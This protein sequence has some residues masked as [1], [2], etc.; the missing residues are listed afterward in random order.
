MTDTDDV[1]GALRRAAQAIAPVAV[2][3]RRTIHRRPEPAYQEHE[4]AALVA[5]VLRD[6]GL[7]VRAGV[8]GTTGVVGLLHG[9]AA[10]QNGGACSGRVLAIRADMDALPIAGADPKDVPYRTTVEGVRHVCGHDAHVAMALGAAQAL[11]Q[12]RDRWAGTVKFVFEPAEESLG[13]AFKPGADALIEAGVLDD[14]PVDAVLALHVFPEYPAGTVAVRPG[15]IMTGMDLLDV[16]VI[17][18]EAHS[19]T[20]QKGADAIVAAAHVIL[21]LQ[22]LASREIDPT[23]AVAVN[24]G[25]IEGGRGPRNLLAGRVTLRGLV[26]ASNPALRAEL[27]ERVTRIANHA[28]AALRARCDVRVTSF[29]PSVN[30]DPVVTERF[31]AAC[32]RALGPERVLRLPL[33]R[34]VGETFCAYSERVP[35]VLAFLG[36][37]NPAK[38]ETMWPSH[39]PRFDVDEDALESGILAL[40]AAALELLTGTELRD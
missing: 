9:A 20:P 15:V 38:P 26:R 24:I 21:A 31:I 13:E 37:G 2:E 3:W 18:E 7:G 28:A 8:G 39:H 19:S 25:T 6:L 36:T 12:L 4:T 5:R 23:E 29:H 1:R 11:S 35:S 33:P 30:N 22:T 10:G 27:P 16:D 14:P 17:G 40:A 32:S 34:L